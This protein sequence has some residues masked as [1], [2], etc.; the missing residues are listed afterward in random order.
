MI[1]KVP[2]ISCNGDIYCKC[3]FGNLADLLVKKVQQV[4]YRYLKEFV[5]D[6]MYY[7]QMQIIC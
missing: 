1:V 3:L 4:R 7:L 6:R 2:F 5:K